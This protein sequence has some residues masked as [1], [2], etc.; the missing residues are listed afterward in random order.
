MEFLQNSKHNGGKLNINI[1]DIPASVNAVKNA[2]C[3]VR[4]LHPQYF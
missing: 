4:N 2:P 1:I 3:F